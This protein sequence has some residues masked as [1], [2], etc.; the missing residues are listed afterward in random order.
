MKH[1][2][3]RS[4]IVFAAIVFAALLPRRAGAAGGEGSAQI[5][6]EAACRLYARA[7]V[8]RTL[9]RL[10]ECRRRYG[11]AVFAREAWLLSARVMEHDLD[12]VDRAL[13]T[14]RRLALK[15]PRS[16]QGVLAQA[17]IA[18]AYASRGRDA[19]AYRE[20]VRLSRFPPLRVREGSEAGSGEGEAVARGALKRRPSAPTTVDEANLAIEWADAHALRVLLGMPTP[21]R[22]KTLPAR[23]ETVA[24]GRAVR[25]GPVESSRSDAAGTTDVRYLLAPPLREFS[26]VECELDGQTLSG[27]SPT[28]R[29]KRHCSMLVEPLFA[30]EPAEVLAL[31]GTSPR[32]ERLT[33]KIVY[34]RPVRLLKVSITVA[35]GRVRIW[36]VKPSLRAPAAAPAAAAPAGSVR[37]PTPDTGGYAPVLLS[38]AGGR[39]LCVYTDVGSQATTSPALISDLYIVRSADS[40]RTW[41]EP[42]RLSV[43][44]ATAEISPALVRFPKGQYVLLW[45][46]DRRGGGCMD[47][48]YALSEDTKS[49]TR[50]APVEIERLDTMSGAQIRL[51]SV[52]AVCRSAELI[53]IL[54]SATGTIRLRTE[55]RERYF[56]SGIY[57]T[58]F[59]RKRTWMEREL[60]YSTRAT[61]IAKLPGS[62]RIE[63]SS[64]GVSPL[65]PVDAAWL[66]PV[67][68]AASWGTDSAGPYLSAG[69]VGGKW[70]SFYSGAAPPAPGASRR[71]RARIVA[72]GGVKGGLVMLTARA[73]GRAPAGGAG[74]AGGRGGPAPRAL[75]AVSSYDGSK[76]S[77][78]VGLGPA[79]PMSPGL[80]GLAPIAPARYLAV[81]GYDSP[82][83]P[84]PLWATEFA[85]PEPPRGKR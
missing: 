23:A 49:W 18:L 71:V 64:A 37:M 82:S 9:S 85:R 24:D 58:G 8:A 15:H 46:S 11:D 62:P 59:T 10:E 34:T 48:Y 32:R 66:G 69:S 25:S 5:E 3:E 21:K 70:R 41:S 17:H 35:G 30:G 33:G 4:L 39:L 19:A 1:A 56:C 36:S 28:P 43:S 16:P 44:G 45:L 29:E 27:S 67:K 54:F 83:S 65:V 38:E 47:L 73:V 7:D 13:R 84:S 74:G 2:L 20:Y 72:L 55:T 42:E 76:W 6:F 14:Y 40:G 22:P 50:P 81:W 51:D 60:V 31:S 80:P 57:A 63:N 61:R 12:E 78:P 77:A 75:Q 79:G 68:A 53:R 52:S 26:S